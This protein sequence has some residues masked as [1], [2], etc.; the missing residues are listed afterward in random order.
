LGKA[1]INETEDEKNAENIEIQNE[2][3]EEAK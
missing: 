2:C 1:K 3:K